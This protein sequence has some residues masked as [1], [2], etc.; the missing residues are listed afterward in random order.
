MQVNIHLVAALAGALAAGA[1]KPAAE[2]TKVAAAEPA[3]LPFRSMR[4]DRCLY[5]ADYRNA[6]LVIVNLQYAVKLSI[7]GNWKDLR[8]APLLVWSSYLTPD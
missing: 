6:A 5:F 4:A 1:A 7:S 2:A 8:M 3:R